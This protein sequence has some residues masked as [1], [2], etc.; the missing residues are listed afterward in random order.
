MTRV[1]FERE[2]TDGERERGRERFVS[3]CLE[4][5]QPQRTTSGLERER[6]REDVLTETARRG[7]EK[8]TDRSRLR[9]KGAGRQW[10]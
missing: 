8:E 3:W 2:F 9:E 1:A 5:S 10:I 6:E 7:I 4:P